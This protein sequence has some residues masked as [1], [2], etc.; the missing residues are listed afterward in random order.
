MSTG[1]FLDP[2]PKYTSYSIFRRRSWSSSIE[3]SSSIAKGAA[4]FQGRLM[5]P[6]EADY[7]IKPPVNRQPKVLQ[8][9]VSRG[10]GDRYSQAPC[11]KGFTGRVKTGRLPAGALLS[12]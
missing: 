7:T 6:I 3:R 2:P 9:R 4:P 12:G 1:G 11:F 5:G 10:S 8:L